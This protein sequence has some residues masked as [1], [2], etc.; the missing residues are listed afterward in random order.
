MYAVIV[1][2]T[3]NEDNFAVHINCDYIDIEMIM[4]YPFVVRIVYC[5]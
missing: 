4:K 3:F 1:L 5:C 2:K